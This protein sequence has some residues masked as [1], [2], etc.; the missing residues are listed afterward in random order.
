MKEWDVGHLE[1]FTGG[2]VA[3]LRQADLDTTIIFI[4]TQFW[5][6]HYRSCRYMELSVVLRRFSIRR[7]G[8]LKRSRPFYQ[9]RLGLGSLH[10]D[11]FPSVLVS[12]SSLELQVSRASDKAVVDVGVRIRLRG[13]NNV[14]S[15]EQAGGKPVTNCTTRR[16]RITYRAMTMKRD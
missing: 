6:S 12:R 14:E 16:R 5:I 3:R 7:R 11:G 8:H 1:V 10:F 15:P 9:S 13:G 2:A 4:A